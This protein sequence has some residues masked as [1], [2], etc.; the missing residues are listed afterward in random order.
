[1]RA[2]STP[3]SGP[4]SPEG[5]HHLALLARVSRELSAGGTVKSAIAR[6]LGALEA[7]QIQRS[8]VFLIDPETGSLECE[9]AH[10]IGA[11]QFRPRMEHGVAGRV[12]DTGKPIVS[13]L[14]A[15]DPA[16]LEDVVDPKAWGGTGWSEVCVPLT[17]AGRP[18]GALAAYF[19]A[20]KATD[21]LATVGALTVIATLIAQ[22]R[23]AHHLEARV[24]PADE[25]HVEPQQAPF[26]YSNMIGGS[27]AMRHVYEQIGQV[28]STNATVL[29]RGESGSGK[30]LV[31]HAIHNN[32]P[33]AKAPFVKLNCAA[34]PETLIEAE[35]FGHERGAFT[36]AHAR[37]KGRFE[38]AEGGTLFLDEVAELSALTQAK[39]L[40]VL[41]FREFERVGG[42]ETIRADLRLVVATNKDVEAAVAAGAFREDLYYRLNVF[43]IVVPPLR[44]R[45]ADI[46]GLAEY[47][48]LKY[49]REHQ[50]RISRISTAATERLAAYAW[51]GNVRELE[52]VIERAVVVCRRN[53]LDERDL[54]DFLAK[55]KSDGP[56]ATPTLDEAVAMVEKRLI[57]Q[58]LLEHN[59]SAAKAARA[60]G[61]SERILRYKAKKYGI[62]AARNNSRL[63]PADSSV[64]PTRSRRQFRRTSELP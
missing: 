45:R 27:V 53:V 48:L 19:Q 59:G 18:I 9:A 25:E 7:L 16:A 6:A 47:F 51:P 36:G 31:A 62:E 61:T 34:L 1:M 5:N 39:L 55:P 10:G 58:A 24:L 2:L 3:E 20:A 28:A 38:L 40:R 57:T 13:P 49:A 46:P 60:L 52:N 26:E 29:V 44:E 56:G 14:V 15:H 32:S 8:A 63:S 4:S 21:F 22:V 50:R 11:E 17:L 30:E 35:L 12:A 23:Q 37:R 41:Q 42:T 54:P 33:R 43:S 64:G